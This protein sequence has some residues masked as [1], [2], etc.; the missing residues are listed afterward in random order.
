M[1]WSPETRRRPPAP[2][3][4]H[5]VQPSP[6]MVAFTEASLLLAIVIGAAMR[7]RIYYDSPLRSV[8]EWL[9]SPASIDTFFDSS[10]VSGEIPC[11]IAVASTIGLNAEPG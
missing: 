8:P 10:S 1:P 3:T 5:L 9:R 4:A 2:G 11:R 7:L 6:G